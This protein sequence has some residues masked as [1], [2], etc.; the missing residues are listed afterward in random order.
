MKKFLYGLTFLFF[1]CNTITVP[2]WSN[3]KDAEEHTTEHFSIYYFDRD[4]E[5][6]FY[7]AE[8]V[9]RSFE[10][11]MADLQLAN[12]PHVINIEIS[13]TREAFLQGNLD[14]PDWLIVQRGGYNTIRL[15]SPNDS[16][17][18]FHDM[19]SITRGV[20]HSIYH[21]YIRD[22]LNSENNKAPFWFIDGLAIYESFKLP[23]AE[24]SKVRM[25]KYIKA[26]LEDGVPTLG[27]LDVHLD[28]EYLFT[29]MAYSIVSFIID[30]H[31]FESINS[32]LKQF[33]EPGHRSR[34]G[35]ICNVFSGAEFDFVFKKYLESRYRE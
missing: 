11:I 7:L 25:E 18:S 10:I 32:L 22:K 17:S 3:M 14:A 26:M 6:A 27:D 24:P 2:L 1:A 8:A 20:V 19:S 29:A 34:L 35:T 33:Y 28:K 23:E 12:Y 16:G 5:Y 13:P 21:F 31:G 9:E 30:K 15:V 4:K